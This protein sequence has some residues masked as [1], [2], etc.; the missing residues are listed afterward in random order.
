MKTKLA[1]MTT[2]LIAL[3][4]GPVLAQTGSETPG[5]ETS[6]N[7]TGEYGTTVPTQEATTLPATGSVWPTVVLLGFAAVG[8]AMACSRRT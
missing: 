1:G 6:P 7:T 3:L 8:G 5:T 2:L 4:V